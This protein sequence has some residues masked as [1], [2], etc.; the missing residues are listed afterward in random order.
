MSNTYRRIVLASRPTGWVVPENFRLETLP[1]PALGP[2]EVLVR[3]GKSYAQPQEIG[4]T[5]IGATVGE[6]VASHH[7]GFTAGSHVRGMLGWPEFGAVNG[8]ALERIDTRNIRETIAEDLA[9]APEAF[10]GLLRGRNFGKQIVK[11]V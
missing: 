6:V 7:P 5:M 1:M 4:A 10:I 9:S 11:L 8:K 3:Q 2:D